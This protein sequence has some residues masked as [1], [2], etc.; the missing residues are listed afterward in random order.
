MK[1]RALRQ[2]NLLFCLARSIFSIHIFQ[3]VGDEICNSVDC[4]LVHLCFILF[5]I[6]MV[7]V[8]FHG[9][10]CVHFNLYMYSLKV[11]LTSYGTTTFSGTYN[12]REHTIYDAIVVTS[13]CCITILLSTYLRT[14]SYNSKSPLIL[15][16]DQLQL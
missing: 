1:K 15:S 11:T 2:G 13:V 14:A 3:C 7:H 16:V 6:K 4:P 9:W 10:Y 5:I 12:V 8:L